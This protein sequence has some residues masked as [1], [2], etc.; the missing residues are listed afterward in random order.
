MDAKLSAQ[1][2]AVQNSPAQASLPLG[3]P[4]SWDHSVCCHAR[5]LGQTCL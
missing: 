4:G 3:L 1:G 5:K 2:T